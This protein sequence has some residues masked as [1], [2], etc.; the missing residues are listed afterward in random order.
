MSF[1][2]VAFMVKVRLK[3]ES[4]RANLNGVAGSLKRVF[5]FLFDSVP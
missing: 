5:S 3:I 4:R 2:V 1:I